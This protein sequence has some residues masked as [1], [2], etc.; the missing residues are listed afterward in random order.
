VK[1]LE[2]T[3]RKTIKKYEMLAAGNG[4]VVGFSGGADSVALLHFLTNEQYLPLL[5]VHVNHGLRGADADADAVF[6]EEF[7]RKIGVDFELHHADVAKFAKEGKVSIEAAGRKLRYEI[8]N[9]AAQKRDFGH[10]AVAH[11]QNDVAETVLLQILRGTGRVRGIAPVRENIIRPLIDVPRSEIEGYCVRH[12]LEYRHD[13]SNDGDG[14][15]RN[16]LRN[17]YLPQLAAEFNPNLVENLAQLAEVSREE[18]EYL[19]ELVGS[20]GERGRSPLQRRWVRGL[21][22]E[23]KGDLENITFDHVEAVLELEKGATGREVALPDGFLARNVYGRVE[24]VKRKLPLQFSYELPLGQDVYVAEID[25]WFYLGENPP[26]RVGITTYNLPVKLDMMTDV[27]VR[28]RMAG[29]KI[30][31]G[32]VGTKKIKNYFIDKKIPR[33]ERDAVVFVANKSDVI[34]MQGGVCD[35]KY[36]CDDGDGLLQIWRELGEESDY[37]LQFCGD[38]F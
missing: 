37:D 11:N 21:I 35:D 34:I 20:A 32:G 19:E 26:K 16:K 9:E 2:K 28:T 4:I 7:C 38:V 14:F 10:I 1:L 17:K 15:A 5:A 36:T 22:R 18:D 3:A 23:A 24:I 30:Y 13:A 31:I 33:H 6:C 27:K 29:D 12:G 25:R 8:F